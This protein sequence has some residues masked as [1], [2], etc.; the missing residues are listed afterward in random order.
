MPIDLITN[1]ECNQLKTKLE[2]DGF[3]VFVL[4]ASKCTNEEQFFEACRN[5]WPMGQASRDQSEAF[6]LSTNWNWNGFADFFWQ[7]LLENSGR[8]LAY[9]AISTEAIHRDILRKSRSC[10]EFILSNN[11]SSTG[12]SQDDVRLF[13]VMLPTA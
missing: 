11:L 5:S 6:L 8:Q 9:F 1:E 7:G 2:R 4:D 13:F 12:H 10:L 3:L